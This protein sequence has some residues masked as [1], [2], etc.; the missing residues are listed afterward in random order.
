MSNVLADLAVFPSS[1]IHKGD[2]THPDS[3]VCTRDANRYLTSVTYGQDPTHPDSWV[4]T[5]DANGEMTSLTY[6]RDPTHPDSWSD[7]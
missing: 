4:C 7:I 5:R 2:P 6:G 1:Y 3:F